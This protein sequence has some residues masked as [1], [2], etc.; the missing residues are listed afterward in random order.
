MRHY[1][2][3]QSRKPISTPV[4]STFKTMHP[5]VLL[6]VFSPLSVFTEGFES[7]IKLGQWM[8]NSSPLGSQSAFLPLLRSSFLL[9]LLS[10]VSTFLSF[11]GWYMVAILDV[12]VQYSHTSPALSDITAPVQKSGSTFR[13][14][15]SCSKI[16]AV[17][18]CVNISI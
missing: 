9:L 14:S 10:I 2:Q 18:I 5:V 12:E 16:I 3:I 7:P 8:E 1:E 6:Q 11:L 13:I 4:H 15:T 17:C